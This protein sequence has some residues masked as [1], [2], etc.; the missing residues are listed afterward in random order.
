VL[1]FRAGDLVGIVN[2]IDDESWDPA[3][4]KTLPAKFSAHD[5]AGKASARRSSRNGSA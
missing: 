3:R 1:R 4:D 2:G 5:L